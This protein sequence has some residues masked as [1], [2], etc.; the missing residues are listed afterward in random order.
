MKSYISE[1][2]AFSFKKMDLKMS[3]IWRRF[4]LG[5]NVLMHRCNLIH[6]IF[7][8]ISREAYNTGFW[9]NIMPPV[10]TGQAWDRLIS[11]VGM[12][13]QSTPKSSNWLSF[14]P[15]RATFL[16]ILLT[17]NNL[18]CERLKATFT[19]MAWKKP[20]LVYSPY[21]GSEM[22]NFDVSFVLSPNKLFNKQSSCRWFDAQVMSL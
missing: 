16:N 11:T 12:L 1:I 8:T 10:Q 17:V 20:R 13:F 9:F 3:A 18:Q 21:R 19:M 4:C 7:I 5:L 22:W 6:G 2:R 14:I 15:I